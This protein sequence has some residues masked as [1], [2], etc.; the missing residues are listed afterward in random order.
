MLFK[1][2]N[3]YKRGTKFDTL[4]IET[5]EYK[6][7]EKENVYATCGSPLTEMKKEIRKELVIICGG[8]NPATPQS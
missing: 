5:I 2:T 3:K 6:L 7:S 8:K 4:P 1:I